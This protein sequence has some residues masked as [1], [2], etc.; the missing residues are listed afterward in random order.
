[1][2]A[3]RSPSEAA[4][5]G[6]RPWRLGVDLAFAAWTGL[7]LYATLV[8]HGFET[9]PYHILFVSFAAVYGFR[10]W[11][12]AVTIAVLGGIVATTGVIFYLHWVDG[13]IPGDEM[14]EIVLMP[15]ILGA[16]VWHARRRFAMQRQV[17]HMAQLERE[18]RLHEHEL[19]RDTSHALRTPLTIAR[20]HIELLRDS[21]ADDDDLVRHDA[22]V[23]L[24]EL[25]RIGRMASRLLAIAE[26]ERP[27]VLSPRAVDLRQLATDVHDR[28]SVS[29]ERRWSLEAPDAMGTLA[30]DDVARIALDALVENAVAVTGP[31]DEVRI[32]C[33][34]VENAALLGVADSGPGIAAEDA[35]AVFQRFWRKSAERGGTGL[36]LAYV[37]AAAEAHGGDVLVARSQLGGALVG[38]RIPLRDPA[39]ATAPMVPAAAPA[40]SA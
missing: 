5:S 12:L 30:D 27:D 16:M 8:M 1:M 39:R 35:K 15:A 14:F 36:G 3:T 23:A 18:R 28:W 21:A 31:G 9:V 34:R 26:L 17:E 10:V 38:I 29:V 19:A 2:S 32:V 11:S 13:Q 40:L 20:G 25:D 6:G 4:A 22:D 7:L 37:R 33:R 24:A